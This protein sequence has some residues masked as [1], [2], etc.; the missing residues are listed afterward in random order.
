MSIADKLLTIAN[1]T[2]EVLGILAP[3]KTVSG[4]AISVSDVSS[5]EHELKIKLLSDYISN[6]SSIMMRKYGKNLYPTTVYQCLAQFNNYYTYRIE[7]N[8]DIIKLVQSLAGNFIRFSFS[9]DNDMFKKNNE[10]LVYFDDGTYWFNGS[11]ILPTGKT[12]THLE[13]RARSDSNAANGQIPNI[14]NIQLELGN[15]PTNY[16]PYKEPQTITAN[17]E[18]IIQGLKSVSPNMTLISNTDSVVIE[19][20]YRSSDSHEG[21][22]KYTE[23]QNVFARAKKLL[24]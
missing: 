21:N 13:F 2:P 20:T 24:K 14:Y 4:L 15:A 23:L 12:V 10:I 18:G 16:E 11:K 7:R 5:I 9:I 8:A 6:F 17:A 1:N 19:C 22:V 3:P